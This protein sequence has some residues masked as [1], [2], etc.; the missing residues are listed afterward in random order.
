MIAVRLAFALVLTTAWAATATAQSVPRTRDGRPDLQGAW[1][2]RSLTTLERR[3]AFKT[4]E[5]PEPEAKAFEAKADGRPPIADDVGQADTEWWEPG[6][7]LARIGGQARSSWIVDPPSGRLPYT[8]AGQKRLSAAQA[9]DRANFDDPEARP[10]PE[11]CLIGG[12]GVMGPPMLNGFY[13][14]NYR[15]V[16]TPD[17]VVIVT[18]MLPNARI[19]PLRPRA[20][21][22][23][24]RRL[25]TGDPAGRWDGDTLVVETRGLHPGGSWRM[26]TR[27]YLSSDARVTER[28]TRISANAI[29]YD[30]IVEDPA[31]YTQPWRGEMVLTPATGP[32]HEYACHEG[33]YSLSGVLAG[34][35]REEREASAPQG[36]NSRPT[37]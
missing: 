31:I 35:R 2:N 30:F 1:T 34:G 18:E 15:I 26:P 17:Y 21:H 10:G 11:R 37:P 8:E 29:R 5:I 28:F 20:P 13:N 23:E 19:V 9:A 4:L 33:N 16:Q 36:S 12:G 24:P 7:A 3:P 32:M 27:L 25:W 14:S 22:P 6:A